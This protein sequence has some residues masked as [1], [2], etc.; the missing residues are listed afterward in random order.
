MST[1]RLWLGTGLSLDR[2]IALLLAELTVEEKAGQLHLGSELDPVKHHGEIVG[3][4]VGAGIYS[5]GANAEP[6]LEQIDLASTIAGCQ[7]LAREES[8]ARHPAAVRQ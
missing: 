6:G 1:Q 8:R 4:H 3:G 7:Q 5:H 2:R